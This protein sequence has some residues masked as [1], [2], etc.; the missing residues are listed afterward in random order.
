MTAIP[1]ALRRNPAFLELARYLNDEGYRFDP[2]IGTRHPYLVIGLPNA[3]TVK[4][5]FPMT[6]SDRRSALNCVSDCKRLI[7]SRMED[8]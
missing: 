5:H 4:M 6:P 2:V 1:K 8:R 3:A 7:R